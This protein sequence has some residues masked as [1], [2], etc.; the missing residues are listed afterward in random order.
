[1]AATSTR[2]TAE[3]ID[4][5]LPEAIFRHWVHV[6]EEDTKA[7]EVYKPAGTPLPPAFG[8]D[9]FEMRKDGRF[10]QYLIGAADAPV[11]A[12]GHWRP[13]GRLTVAVDLVE[14]RRQDFS[15]EIVAVDTRELKIHRL[16]VAAGTLMD[17]PH[18]PD[19][20][21]LPPAQTHRRI[22]FERAEVRVFESFPPQRVLVVSGIKPYM[23]M[24]VELVPVVYVRQPEYWEIEV[25]GSLRG[26]GLPAEAPYTV[27]L[28]LA[29]ST[30]SRGIV[31]MGA[32][33]LQRFDVPVD[34]PQGPAEQ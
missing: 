30:G 31:V 5:S 28:N 26:V 15:F 14:A 24:A 13:A 10:V 3:P 22:D 7:Y 9:G 34:E 2:P 18:Q 20:G 21:T 19:M 6:R 25:V 12:F 11:A 33:R 27:S 32:T 4:K 29:A 16:P 1:M 8:R 17:D 23:N